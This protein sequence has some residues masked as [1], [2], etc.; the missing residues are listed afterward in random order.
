MLGYMPKL[1][2]EYPGACHH[3]IDRG[4]CLAGIFKMEAA[5]A[6]FKSCLFDACERPNRILRA[7][8]VMSNQYVGRWCRAADRPDF[9][10]VPEYQT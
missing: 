7:F 3:V 4:H 9:E 2:Q 8:V 1:R 6:A 10:K 5:R